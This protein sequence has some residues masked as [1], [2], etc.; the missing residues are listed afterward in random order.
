MAYAYLGL[1]KL[2]M[3]NWDN[4]RP[5]AALVAEGFH[6]YLTRFLEMSRTNVTPDLEDLA[7]AV[8]KSIAFVAETEPPYFIDFTAWRRVM[9]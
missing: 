5:P 3:I 1:A 9:E 4:R 2:A 8:R 7:V 6:P